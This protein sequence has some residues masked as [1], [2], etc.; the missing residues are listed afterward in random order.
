M[1]F[2]VPT[3]STR[4]M[5]GWEGVPRL[6]KDRINCLDRAWKTSDHR[7][8]KPSKISQPQARTDRLS[9][10]YQPDQVHIGSDRDL[11]TLIQVLGRSPQ[12]TSHYQEHPA[13]HL[14]ALKTRT[15]CPFLGCRPTRE[16]VSKRSGSMWNLKK[17]LPRVLKTL[18]R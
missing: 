7:E 14:Q 13:Y 8:T 5:V 4:G 16:Q 1:T 10:D 6:G 15:S 9:Q 18:D 11:S 17:D 12:S 3:I 2:L